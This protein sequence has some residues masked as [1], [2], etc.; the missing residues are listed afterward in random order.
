MVQYTTCK[1]GSHIALEMENKW[2][3]SVPFVEIVD[4]K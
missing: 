2:I 4:A 3:G 1:I